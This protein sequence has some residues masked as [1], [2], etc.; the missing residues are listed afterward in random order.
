MTFT[1]RKFLTVGGS[2]A[3]LATVGCDQV[4]REV[5]ALYESK[6]SGPFA[7]PTSDEIDAIAHVLNRAAFGARPGDYSRILKMATTPED[8]AK[9]YIE[10]QLNPEAIDDYDATHAVRRFETLNEPLGELF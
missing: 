1:R 4:P 5:R 9:A 10:Q 2:A 8:A 6:N 7:P 3:L